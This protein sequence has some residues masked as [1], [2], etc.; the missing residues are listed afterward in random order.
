MIEFQMQSTYSRGRI[1]NPFD[2]AFVSRA[3]DPRGRFT[4]GEAASLAKETCRISYNPGTY[5]LEVNG[6]SFKANYL[7]E[8]V[9]AHPGRNIL[10]DATTLDFPDI[11][12]IIRAYVEQRQEVCFSF[13]YAEPEEYQTSQ[14]ED[15]NETPRFVLSDSFDERHR[16]IPGFFT[17]TTSERRPAWVVV[18][19]GFEGDRL[20]RLV[21]DAEPE[22]KK[23]YNLVFGV[24]PYRT[25]W[26]NHSLME[27][28]HALSETERDDIFYAG[29]NNP[30]SCFEV[31]K[32]LHQ[33]AKGPNAALELAPLGTKP[34]AIACAIF[35]GCHREIGIRYDYPK[36]SENRSTGIGRTH[37]FV[38]KADGAELGEF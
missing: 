8:L 3:L 24:P 2:V 25:L 6:Q 18:F 23:Q 10:L 27:N 17:G 31:I 35:A 22:D 36:R 29:A 30:F 7:D 38:V 19:L 1:T 34:A 28:C 13:L 11:L 4:A 16:P 37:L 20:R 32:E 15:D 9:K 12:L 21:F 33:A 5:S 26:E 14:F